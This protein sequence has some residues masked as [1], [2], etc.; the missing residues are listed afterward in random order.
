MTLAA[1][2]RLQIRP[3]A[4]FR[5]VLRW[6]GFCAGSA[7][8]FGQ[9]A[10]AEWKIDPLASRL[11][12]HVSPAGLLASALHPHRFQPE[13]WSGEIRW[14]PEHPEAASVEVRIA[15][16]SLRDHQ[17]KLSASDI[18]KVEAQTRGPRI[19]DAEKFPSIRFQGHGLS[20]PTM[21]GGGE[22]RATLS[23]DLTL[24]GRT[25]PVQFPIQGRV[26]ADRMEAT[27]TVKLRQTDFGIRPYSTALGSIAVR[28]EVT[29][30][31]SLVAVRRQA[32]TTE[33]GSSKDVRP[34]APSRLQS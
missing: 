30:E 8:A 14:D 12:V 24:H 22:V 19:L 18:A 10:A 23:G 25:R 4:A 5:L 1:G 9:A 20:S 6:I 29:I 33:P 13:S 26:S 16:D 34:Q 11:V 2:T 3:R 32:G 17:E 27:A 15:A 28:D 7:F 21:S 31:I